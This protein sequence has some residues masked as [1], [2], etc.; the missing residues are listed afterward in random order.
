MALRFLTEETRDRYIHTLGVSTPK[1]FLRAVFF[2]TLM[3][4]HFHSVKMKSKTVFRGVKILTFCNSFPKSCRLHHERFGPRTIHFQL[5]NGV[6]ILT[7]TENDLYSETDEMG[8]SSQWHQW[9]GLG[10]V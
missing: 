9:Q 1:L 7:D 3:E 4:K 2:P 8:K 6:F 10:A 5:I